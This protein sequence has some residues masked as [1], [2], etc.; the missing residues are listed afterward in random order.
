MSF[1][2]S[3]PDAV[4]PLRVY[5]QFI[6][7]D[8]GANLPSKYMYLAGAETDAALFGVPS[9][10]TLEVIDTRIDALGGGSFPNVAYQNRFY[11]DG[12]TYDGRVLGAAIDTDGLS[13]RLSGSHTIGNVGFDWGLAQV[14]VN[15]TDKSVNRLSSTAVSGLVADL[16]A[17]YTLRDGTE[18]SGGIAY[19]GFALDNADIPE[20]VSATAMVS[21]RF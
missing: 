4:A 11:P 21:R 1:S 19:Q 14:R 3:L 2:Y 20:G 17:S 8:E 9:V 7:E 10:L 12:Y 5:A 15:D 6:G 16:G 18:L 13:V